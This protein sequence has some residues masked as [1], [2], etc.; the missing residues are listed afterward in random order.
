MKHDDVNSTLLELT[1][2]AVITVG[3]RTETSPLLPFLIPVDYTQ[4]TKSY[5]SYHDALRK[6]I[7]LTL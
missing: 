6:L 2:T 7:H 1:G 3:C 4:T 5:Y